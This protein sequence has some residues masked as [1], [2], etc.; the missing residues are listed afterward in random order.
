PLAG[1]PIA[2]AAGI[3]MGA[4]VSVQSPP[5]III[6][7]VTSVFATLVLAGTPLIPAAVLVLSLAL[8]AYSIAG[9][10]S[11]IAAGRKRL[12]LD[13]EARKAVT[14]VDE[15]ENS[16][17]GWFWET[18]AEGTLSYVSQQLADDFQCE[19][20]ELV[21]LPFPALPWVERSGDSAIEERKTLGFHLSARFPFSDVIVR[22][23]SDEDI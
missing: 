18:N 13:A 8:V 19:A 23:A 4:I 6:N 20:P 9:T 17:R 11:F 22:A 10:R 3:A 16:G 14:F 7:M 2:M 5:L 15:F 1:A 21:A 12:N